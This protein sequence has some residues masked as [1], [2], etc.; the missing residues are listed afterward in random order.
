LTQAA[1]WNDDAG[2]VLSWLIY[3]AWFHPF[4]PSPRC[5][6]LSHFDFLATLFYS[7][8]TLEKTLI[9][10]KWILFY[11]QKGIWKNVNTNIA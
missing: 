2:P 10:K 6:A 9:A 1:K 7:S 5:F 8:S 3:P 11:T 4:R